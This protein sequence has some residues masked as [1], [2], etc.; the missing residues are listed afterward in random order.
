MLT[1]KS[2]EQ[3]FPSDTMREQF[4]KVFS[5]SFFV[6]T[7]PKIFELRKRHEK[8]QAKLGGQTKKQSDQG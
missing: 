5:G 2:T 4:D 1:I 7:S 8:I 3:N 6:P